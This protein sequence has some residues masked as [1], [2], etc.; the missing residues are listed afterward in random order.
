M[1]PAAFLGFLRR[2]RALKS[3]EVRPFSLVPHTISAI[4]QGCCRQLTLLPLSHHKNERVP[5]GVATQLAEAL[6][7]GAL[8]MLEQLFLHWSWEPGSFKRLFSALATGDRNVRAGLPRVR[9][10]P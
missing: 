10:S 6:E 9:R 1:D 4:G 2:L 7:A 8:P 5:I 3:M